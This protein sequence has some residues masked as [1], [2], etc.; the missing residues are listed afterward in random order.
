[1]PW[2]VGTATRE[3]AECVKILQLKKHV[4]P[5]SPCS[6]QSSLLPGSWQRPSLLNCRPAP[7]EA[8]G[9]D[10]N[11]TSEKLPNGTIFKTYEV[12]KASSPGAGRPGWSRG[13]PW[14]AGW[15]RKW[16]RLRKVG[17][18]RESSSGVRG[19]WGTGHQS[20]TT[21]AVTTTSNPPCNSACV[22]IAKET[23]MRGRVGIQ[24]TKRGHVF[25]RGA[26]ARRRHPGQVVDR[27]QSIAEQRRPTHAEHNAETVSPA[28]AA[29]HRI[30]W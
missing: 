26:G 11:N 27:R 15:C 23:A 20:S 29:T 28:A 17:H 10:G 13:R 1:M 12:T 16:Q 4:C 3:M 21:V 18:S 24:H 7:N 19:S 22:D 2:L 25:P 9:V 5:I 6:S 8:S 30:S 14:P